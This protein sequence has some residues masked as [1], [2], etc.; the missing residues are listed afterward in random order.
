MTTRHLAL[1]SWLV[2]P[3]DNP[4]KLAKSV[5]LPA[6]AMLVDMNL[7]GEPTGAGTRA[8]VADWFASHRADAAGFQRW[9]RIKPVAAPQWR[10]DLAAVMASA[11]DGIVM[12][13]PENPDEVRRLASEIYEL[14][15][16]HGLA[17]NSIRLVL[18]LGMTAR[19]ALAIDA[20]VADAHPRLAGL[21]WDPTGLAREIGADSAARGLF[22]DLRTRLLLS[23]KALGLLAIEGPQPQWRDADATMRHARS[24]K[25][26]GFDA[27]LAIHPAQLNPINVIFRA[28]ESERKRAEAIVAAFDGSPGAAAIYFEGRMLDRTH[29][30]RA[31]GILETG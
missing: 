23:A 27:M 8:L 10:E 4:A 20:I 30:D 9:L 31:R 6:D 18:Q 5:A 3:G 14:E 11:P 29:L 21:T 15:Q 1:R 13:G 26:D 28:G 19:G 24:A 7:S 17:T 25:Q 22:A 12:S 2:I 16:S